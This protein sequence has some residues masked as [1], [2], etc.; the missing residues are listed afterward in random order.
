MSEE[1]I[2]TKKGIAEVR[3]DKRKNW[4]FRF[5]ALNGRILSHSESYKIKVSAEKGRLASLKIGYAYFKVLEKEKAKAKE[6][7]ALKKA[8]DGS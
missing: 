1:V 7:A 5:K 8:T 4:F 6:K 2:R 3:Q